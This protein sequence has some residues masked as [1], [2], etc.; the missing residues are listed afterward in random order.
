MKALPI[1]FILI[2]AIHA[3]SEYKVVSSIKSTSNVTL[4]L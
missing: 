2:V 1:L 3:K 4:Q